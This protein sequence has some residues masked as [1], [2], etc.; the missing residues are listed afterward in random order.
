MSTIVS[1]H[2]DYASSTSTEYP[3]FALD[4]IRQF[5]SAA[6]DT[7]R[8]GDAD[9]DTALIM[10]NVSI[11]AHHAVTGEHTQES[12]TSY[13]VLASVMAHHGYWDRTDAN[14][15]YIRYMQLLGIK[16]STISLGRDYL[17]DYD[18]VTG[19]SHGRTLMITSP[20]V[21]TVMRTLNPSQVALDEV[22]SQ[23]LKL[24]ENAQLGYQEDQYATTTYHRPRSLRRENHQSLSELVHTRMVSPTRALLVNNIFTVD[25]LHAMLGAAQTPQGAAQVVKLLE[26]CI[27]LKDQSVF[28][29]D[30]LADIV[31]NRDHDDMPGALLYR[32][33]FESRAEDVD[34]TQWV[35]DPFRHYDDFPFELVTDALWH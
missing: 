11:V 2:S 10:V 13:R 15:Q 33:V 4:S 17:F 31:N 21:Q 24:I 14:Q 28:A 5:L 30:E 18:W 26:H 12:I 34:P 32:L 9:V 27:E 3:A 25:H 23:V 19:V 22:T 6:Q 35:A 7:A 16:L 29:M 20:L 8:W 1:G